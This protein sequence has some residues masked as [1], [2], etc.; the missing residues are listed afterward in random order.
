MADDVEKVKVWPAEGVLIR[1]EVTG[2]AIEPGQEVALT[3]AVLRA[4]NAGDLR[5]EPPGE[6]RATGTDRAS[7]KGRATGK[8]LRA[9]PAEEQSVEPH[10]PY[11]PDEPLERGGKER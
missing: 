1:D 2:A 3:R 10:R 9:A 8:D 4:L 6:E 7:G 5:R 11:N